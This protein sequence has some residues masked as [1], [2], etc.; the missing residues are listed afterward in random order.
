MLL[1]PYLGP[2]FV[3]ALSLMRVLAL[4]WRSLIAKPLW[5]PDMTAKA[6]DSCRALCI[7]TR[8]HASRVGDTAAPGNIT[9]QAML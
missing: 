6:Q 7:M 9:F 2:T 5:L 3:D 1:A 8:S 4:A